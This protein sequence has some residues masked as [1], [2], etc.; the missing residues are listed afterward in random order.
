[1][2]TDVTDGSPYLD[3]L[4]ELA[5]PVPN[6]A[7]TLVTQAEEEANADNVNFLRTPLPQFQNEGGAQDRSS[8]SRVNATTMPSAEA[9]LEMQ[10]RRR[11]AEVLLQRETGNIRNAS[12]AQRPSSYI[13]SGYQGW[14]PGTVENE[15]EE[16]QLTMNDLRIMARGHRRTGQS[17]E[18]QL[19]MNDL[20][21]LARGHIGAGQDTATRRHFR[22]QE[23]RQLGTSADRRDSI[24]DDMDW[25]SDRF[26][27]AQ[28]QQT[29]MAEYNLRTTALLQSV[30][31]HAR[32][33]PRSWNRNET[34]R[35]RRL[36]EDDDRQRSHNNLA[37]DRQ[38]QDL[39]QD[40]RLGITS[41][42]RRARRTDNSASETSHY[43]EEAIKYLERL[44]YCDSYSDRI[45]SAEAGGFIR[46]EHFTHSHEDF[47]LDTT[48]ISQPKPSS[49]LRAGGVFS[50]SQHA[51]NNSPVPL[52]HFSS[53]SRR[54]TP[55]EPS[56]RDTQ[57]P[58]T[59]SSAG[60]ALN[61]SWI[62]N[63][64]SRTS[65]EG[66]GSW[67]VKVTINS[68]DYEA[69]TLTGTMEAFNVPNKSSPAQESSI[70]TYLEGEIIDFNQYTL[71]TKS[72]NADS[73]VDSTYWRKLEPFKSLSDSEV[74]SNLV[75]MKWLCEE[76]AQKWVLMRWKGSSRPGS[77]NVRRKLI[78][79]QR[80]ASS[81]HPMS[82]WD[83]R[84]PASITYQ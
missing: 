6:L 35:E 48:I 81:R 7:A 67:P 43:L 40:I 71:E 5:T 38:A 68:I 80:N 56:I 42:L 33:S 79:P 44:R 11:M 58:A 28:A 19:T 25:E 45:S 30:R 3:Q 74:V 59:E 54:R 50:G 60:Q 77:V 29:P 23:L 31:R 9:R 15:S 47:I 82:R 49:W 13:P 17:D 18:P 62:N 64:I 46:G 73:S 65:A 70:T 26:D 27:N 63:V 21:L 83:S 84:F 61:G 14:A 16:P 72:F 34:E 12:P 39:L 24:D 4:G 66:S 32:F 69:M 53:N 10:R 36:N 55:R 37:A 41:D 51:T 52:F 1:M 75:S 78:N 8:H 22:E 76:F 57:A 2:P 20:R